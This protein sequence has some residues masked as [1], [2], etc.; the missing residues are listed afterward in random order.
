MLVFGMVENLLIL[1]F[2]SIYVWLHFEIF[3]VMTSLI[4]F[5]IIA[6]ILLESLCLL[7]I[8]IV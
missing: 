3:V 1:L 6:W 4:G 2:I 8:M 7:Y 5:F